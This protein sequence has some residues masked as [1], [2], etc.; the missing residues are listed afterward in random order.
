[1][2]IAYICG[3][4]I[5]AL[6]T[7]CASVVNGTH[8]SISVETIPAQNAQ[9]SLENSKGKWYINNTPGSTTVH[10]S[11]SDL[12]VTCKKS[13]YSVS[14]SKIKSRTHPAAFGN[15]LLG[16]VVGAGIDVANGAAYSYPTNI[17]VP[18]MSAKKSKK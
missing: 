6:L 10:R 2:K 3:S 12:L 13:G 17:K 14:T 16:G 7:S 18:L 1:M 4:L 5:L 11:I 15:I 8:Q 9:C